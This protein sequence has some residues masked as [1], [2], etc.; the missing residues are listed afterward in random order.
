[1][2]VLVRVGSVHP[3]PQ[4]DSAG[5]FDAPVR[6]GPA[7]GADPF[8]GTGED[9]CRVAGGATRLG[10]LG[11]AAAPTGG[12]AAAR[13]SVVTST[14]EL[15]TAPTGMGRTAEASGVGDSGTVGSAAEEPATGAERLTG[16]AETAGTETSTVAGRP[17]RRWAVMISMA[18]APPV[19][20]KHPPAAMSLP[21]RRLSLARR[22]KSS[23]GSA[24]AS[25]GAP[26]DGPGA[27]I[28]AALVTGSGV[29]A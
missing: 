8:A 21:Q 28:G 23:H 27:W 13:G 26:A 11:R 18:T 4:S 17:E 5:T 9:G 2:G 7:P 22:R 3:A 12:T 19:R 10:G 16:G 29:G 20:T 6:S 25:S 24:R 14:E 15:G 1:M